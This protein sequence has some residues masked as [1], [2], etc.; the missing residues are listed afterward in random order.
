MLITG[1]QC[2]ERANPI[3]PAITNLYHITKAR[4]S[5][6]VSGSFRHISFKLIVNPKHCSR[7]AYFYKYLSG[8]LGIYETRFRIIISYANI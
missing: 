8:E 1:F 6:N 4:T 2:P 3:R 7:G 5:G